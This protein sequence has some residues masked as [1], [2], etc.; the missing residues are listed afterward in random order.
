MATTHSELRVGTGLTTEITEDEKGHRAGTKEGA[1]LEPNLF[2]SSAALVS[3]ARSVVK[4]SN[5]GCQ[6]IFASCEKGCRP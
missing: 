1:D 6:E 3:F 4:I 2:L 5:A